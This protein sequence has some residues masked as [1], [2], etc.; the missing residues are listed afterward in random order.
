MLKVSIKHVRN[1][2]AVNVFFNFSDCTFNKKPK[3]A[4][5]ATGLQ[6]IQNTFVGRWFLRVNY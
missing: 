1:H 6:T 4:M 3:S 5:Q 2:L